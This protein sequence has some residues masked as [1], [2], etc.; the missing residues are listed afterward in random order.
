M[1]LDG[2]VRLK[3]GLNASRISR[4]DGG[5]SFA[6]SPPPIIPDADL[7]FVVM[8]D[9]WEGIPRYAPPHGAGF[10]QGISIQRLETAGPFGL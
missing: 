4:Y 6:F 9:G 1:W 7:P 8:P 2:H 5:K 10:E 3:Q